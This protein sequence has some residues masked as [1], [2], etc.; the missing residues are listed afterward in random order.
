MFE[1]KVVEK[2]AKCPFQ[3]PGVTGYLTAAGTTHC[4]VCG[5]VHPSVL[6]SE[7]RIVP[8]PQWVADGRDR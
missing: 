6:G 7:T 1:E 4:G 3:I 5:K 8:E 2:Q